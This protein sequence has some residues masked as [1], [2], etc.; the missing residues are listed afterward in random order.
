MCPQQTN[1]YYPSICGHD[2]ENLELPVTETSS[3]T[4]M[5]CTDGAIGSSE[6]ESK[7]AS[8]ISGFSNSVDQTQDENGD[9][10][11][12]NMLPL[13]PG[14][15]DSVRLIGDCGPTKVAKVPAS[16]SSDE[17]QF[18]LSDIDDFEPGKNPGESTFPDPVDKERFV[19]MNGSH[20]FE[21][22]T[23][24]S[25]VISSPISIPRR[26]T[27][28]GPD[29]MRMAE[30]LPNMW[31]DIDDLGAKSLSQ[32]LSHSLES[33][34]TSLPL[35]CTNSDTGNGNQS[36]HSNFNE[37]DTRAQ[38]G[39]KDGVVNPAVGKI[40]SHLHLLNKL[41]GLLLFLDW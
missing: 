39:D 26:H 34:S 33:N 21:S 15:V 38:E 27:D 30:S 14:S 36:P 5:V 16:E 7:G 4:H 1:P 10:I 20:K 19:Q 17:D 2:R 40:L 35:N 8:S 18:F 11:T 13:H 6:G 9:E 31:S 32:P 29:G 37:E 25:K 12:R 3:Y 24:N 22:L 28:H 41:C 23:E